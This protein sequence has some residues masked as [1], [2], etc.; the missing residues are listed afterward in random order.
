MYLS[1]KV[2]HE[3][4]VT[5]NLTSNFQLGKFASLHVRLIRRWSRKHVHLNHSHVKESEKLLLKP[6]LPEL[7]PEICFQRSLLIM[8]LGRLSK[9]CE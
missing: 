8:S 4:P 7:N 5:S 9:E 2:G 6:L 3:G 1:R